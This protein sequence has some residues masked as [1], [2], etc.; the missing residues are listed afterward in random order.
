ML[1][2]REKALRDAR[3]TFDRDR[4]QWQQES[5]Q[6]LEN[7]EAVWKT[8]EAARFVAANVQWQEKLSKVT[9]ESRAEVQAFRERIGENDRLR[10]ELAEARAS[11]AARDK[12]LSEARLPLASA[13]ECWQRDAQESLAAAEAAWKADQA[14]RLASAEAQWR[15][16]SE[17]TRA[18]LASRC[19]KAEKSAVEA[20]TQADTFAARDQNSRFELRRLREELAI[21]QANLASREAELEAARAQEAQP[22]EAEIFLKSDPI[23][24]PLHS[25]Q[26]ERPK[27][28]PHLMRDVVIV[29]CLGVAAVLFWPRIEG[30]VP[31]LAGML[32]N[33]GTVSTSAPEAPE[34]EAVRPSAVVARG[35]NVRSGPSANAPSSGTLPAGAKVEPVEKRG[36]WTF[37]RIEGNAQLHEGWVFSSFLQ[38]EKPADAKPADA[39]KPATAAKPK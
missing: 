39:K 23:G 31:Q 6:A 27:P 38:D 26:W 11:L 19:E 21:A 37:V 8:G 17:N 29:A 1:A 33:G 34:P 12:E 35:A 10:V 36:N 24:G 15:R 25:S 20:R 32:N 2:E 28:K 4:A 30:Y 22:A 9:D 18:E 5:R 14:T 16:Q 7:A 3:A 13:R